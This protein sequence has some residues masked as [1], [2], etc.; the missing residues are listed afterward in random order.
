MILHHVTTV[1]KQTRQTGTTPTP[2]DECMHAAAVAIW[3]DPRDLNE[4]DY[5]YCGSFHIPARLRLVR[6]SS[7]T[8]FLVRAALPALAVA[9]EPGTGNLGLK[10]QHS[11]SRASQGHGPQ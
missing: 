11:S 6:L 4:A 9:R 1:A 3:L 5:S 2:A 8:S 7:S 10:E